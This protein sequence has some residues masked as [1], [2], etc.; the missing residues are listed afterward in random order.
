MVLTGILV[1]T[2][3]CS[4]SILIKFSLISSIV[5]SLFTAIVSV[6]NGPATVAIFGFIFFAIGICYACA[7]W[8]AIPFATANLITAVHAVRANAGLVLV[9]YIFLALAFI[10][11][12]IWTLCVVGLYNTF[13]SIN[14]GYIF[15]LFVSYFWT[16]QVIQ[17]TV[18]VTVAGVSN[19]EK[20]SFIIKI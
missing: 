11:S 8:K 12:I 5:L 13:D 7:V 10:W 14:N 1:N 6:L 15:L 3:I 9:A 16:H 4:A 18:H 19:P 17:N 20:I 2:M